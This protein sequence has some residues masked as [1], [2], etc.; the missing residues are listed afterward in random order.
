MLNFV[1]NSTKYS[2]QTKTDVFIWDFCGSCQLF[3]LWIKMEVLSYNLPYP[4]SH[5][6]Y[7]KGTIFKVQ[8]LW[9]VWWVVVMIWYAVMQAT[10]VTAMT[11]TSRFHSICQFSHNKTHQLVM[12]CIEY[13][14]LNSGFTESC[15]LG[16]FF[17]HKGIWVVSPLKYLKW[18]G[19]AQVSQIF[20]RKLME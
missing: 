10:I 12:H 7:S 9:L 19:S 20:W 5:R 3:W 1:P 13:R 8:S 15:S 18:A 17:P 2:V 14:Y 4:H 11:K 6:L 16:Q